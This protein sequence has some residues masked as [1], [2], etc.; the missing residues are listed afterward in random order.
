MKPKLAVYSL[1]DA[2]IPVHVYTHPEK[3]GSH[4]HH[5]FCLFGKNHVWTSGVTLTNKK[6]TQHRSSSLV[7]DH[8]EVL[9]KY[10]EEFAHIKQVA[11]KKLTT[12]TGK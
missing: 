3:K 2:G 7:L 5:R 12:L 8:K 6:S 4:M 10:E 9:G 11:A 1:V